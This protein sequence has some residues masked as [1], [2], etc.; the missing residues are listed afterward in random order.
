M[1]SKGKEAEIRLAEETDFRAV[2][3]IR[4]KL[5][6]PASADERLEQEQNGWWTSRK[7]KREEAEK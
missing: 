3:E 7:E 1:L 4:Q 2:Y 5:L 6:I